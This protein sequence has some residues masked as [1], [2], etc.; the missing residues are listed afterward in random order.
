MVRLDGSGILE[1]NTKSPAGFTDRTLDVGSTRAFEVAPASIALLFFG[2]NADDFSALAVFPKM[3]V[4]F[5]QGK[6][7]VIPAD[8]NVGAWL[9]TCSPL[10][11]NNAACRYK[12]PAKPFYAK[13]LRIAV[14]PVAGAANTFFVCHP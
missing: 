13:P 9:E 7:C 12:F 4:T 11:H 2:K 8:A 14:T 5:N 6:Q 1:Q 10:S 3:H